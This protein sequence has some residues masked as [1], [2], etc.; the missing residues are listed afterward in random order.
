MADAAEHDGDRQAEMPAI[1]AE[2]LGDL[3]RELAGRRSAP[4][5]RQ[6]LRCAGRRLAARRWM[7]GSAK[8]AVLPVP[9]WAIP[10]RSRP[11]RTM[12]MALAWIGVGAV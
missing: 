10:S 4:D 1:G 7:M 8:A 6:P 2:A 3:A 9:V 5:T 12:G 11:A